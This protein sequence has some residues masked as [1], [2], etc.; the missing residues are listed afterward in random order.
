MDERLEELFP[1]Y[2]L[3]A[4]TDEE[5]AQVESYIAGDPQAK[6]R[7]D[8]LTQTASMLSYDIAPVGPSP[9][10]KKSLMDRVSADARARAADSR[11][12]RATSGFQPERSGFSLSRLFAALSPALAVLSLLLAIIVGGWALV[13]NNEVAQLRVETAA[14]KKALADQRTVIAQIAAPA[15]QIVV[16]AGTEHQPKAHGHLIAHKDGSAVLVV[17][18]LDRLQAGRV[19]QLWLIRGDT[20]MSAGV[21]EVDETGVAVVQVA[22]VAA[23]GAFN[24]VGVSVEPTGGSE[25]PTGDIV[26]FGQA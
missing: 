23:P 7:L 20:P 5:R 12:P 25:T 14:L 11:R 8:E 16:V 2:A 9:E 19:Y 22:T 17:S 4:L 18:G 10:L 15:D 24:A 3:G 6:A 1:L 26:M 21:F 13:L